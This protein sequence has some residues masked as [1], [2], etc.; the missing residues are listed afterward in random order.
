MSLPKMVNLPTHIV[1]ATNNVRARIL[2]FGYAPRNYTVISLCPLKLTF[3]KCILW[4]FIFRFTLSHSISKKNKKKK[5]NF[6]THT[7]NKQNY[8]R[9]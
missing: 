9:R 7:L 8:L 5:S 2:I 6:T 3:R 4:N 1:R